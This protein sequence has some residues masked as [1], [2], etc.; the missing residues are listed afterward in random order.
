LSIVEFRLDAEPVTSSGLP[1]S[2]NRQTV[3]PNAKRRRAAAAVEFALVALPLFLLLIGLIDYGLVFFKT[4]HIT[5]A[6]RAGARR[7]AVLDAT[8]AQ[9]EA[10][11]AAWMNEANI[12]DYDVAITPGNWSTD[13]YPKG[14]PIKVQV[15]V[16]KA[17][18]PIINTGLVPVPEQ[19]VAA[20]SMAKE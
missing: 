3:S 11:V 8:P 10:V 5:Q 14:S 12:D 16:L 9:V 15:T 17:E 19:I 20:A 1:V 7:A 2:P 18:L 6:A 13:E 4:Q